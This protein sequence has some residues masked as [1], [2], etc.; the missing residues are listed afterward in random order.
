MHGQYLRVRKNVAA[1][2]REQGQ[3]LRLLMTAR[4]MV[5]GDYSNPV[6]YWDIG[7]F[8]LRNETNWAGFVLTG[9][10]DSDE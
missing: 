10:P 5:E 3:P 9:P 8:K 1:F 2:Q 7:G 6:P 4:R